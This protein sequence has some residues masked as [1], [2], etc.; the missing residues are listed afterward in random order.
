MFQNVLVSI[1]K[2]ST[3]FKVTTTVLMPLY[4]H[5]YYLQHAHN[6]QLRELNNK[7]ARAKT[8]AQAIFLNI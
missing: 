6:M 4:R 8:M 3:Y 2:W 1:K 7:G 5:F